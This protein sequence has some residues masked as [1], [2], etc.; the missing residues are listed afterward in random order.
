MRNRKEAFRRRQV[1]EEEEK[2]SSGYDVEEM[3]TVR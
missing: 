3:K 2:E 1:K